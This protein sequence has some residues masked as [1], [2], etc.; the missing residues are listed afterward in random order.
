MRRRV[1]WYSS[2][3]HPLLLDTYNKMA[4]T[5]SSTYIIS[6]E[7]SIAAAVPIEE[8]LRIPDNEPV[9]AIPL[10]VRDVEPPVPNPDHQQDNIPI[11]SGD[12]NPVSIEERSIPSPANIFR[13]V[14]FMRDLPETV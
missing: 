5:H 8:R 12:V 10:S 2:S 14:A 7:S 9:P 3:F 6:T 4:A 13:M 11:L 1:P